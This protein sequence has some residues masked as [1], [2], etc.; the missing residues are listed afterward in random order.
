MFHSSFSKG[1][2]A[3][4]FGGGE[5]AKKARKWLE[6]IHNYEV[7]YYLNSYYKNTS[8]DGLPVKCLAELSQSHLDVDF[9]I[10][11]T[12]IMR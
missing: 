3:A 1:Q 5:V 7:K 12:D 11:A 8:F 6:D 10:I 4:V 2:S 9:V